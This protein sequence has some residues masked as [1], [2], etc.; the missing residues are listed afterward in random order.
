MDI[1]VKTTMER[2]SRAKIRKVKR[3]E[4]D[5]HKVEK[6]VFHNDNMILY[7]DGE[8]YEFKLKDISRG[9]Y[10]ATKKERE[11]YQVICSGYGIN[12]PLFY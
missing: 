2:I 4:D 1:H 11:A 8:V 12:W 3:Q 5:F 10:N 6:I 9:L 7:A